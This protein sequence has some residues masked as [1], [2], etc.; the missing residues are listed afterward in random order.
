MSLDANDLEAREI[1]TAVFESKGID[2]VPVTGF[3]TNSG[4]IFGEG[5]RWLGD[6]W[7]YTTAPTAPL[8]LLRE[9]EHATASTLPGPDDDLWA[10]QWHFDFLGDIQKIWEDYTGLGIKV[11]IHDDGMD[12]TF[13]DVDGVPTPVVDH[14]DLA[15]NYDNT[16]E[17]WI[18]GGSFHVDPY[19]TPLGSSTGRPYYEGSTHGTAVAGLIAAARN[20]VG[21]VGVAY[22]STFSTVDI[23]SGYK[24]TDVN[25][26]FDGFFE[27]ALQT[28]NF[29]VVNNS[30][31]DGAYFFQEFIDPY[32]Y[33]K[34][35]ATVD[36]WMYALE[37]G[38]DGLGTLQVKA[39][40]N[41]NLNANGVSS[42]YS[43]ATII[44]GAFDDD[45]DAAYYSNH[46]ANLLV[47]APS[48]GYSTIIETFNAG[49]VTTDRSGAFIDSG[50]G[51]YLYGYNGLRDENGQRIS[52]W[53]PDFGGTSGATP[54][55]TGVIALLLQANEDLGWRDVQNIL[56][57]SAHEQGSGVGGERLE[58]ETNRWLYNN[59]DNW[60]GGGLHFSN[61]YGFGGVD[62]YNAVRMAE[63]WTLFGGPKASLNETS[64][65]QSTTARVALDDGK[66]T[67][68]NFTF[69]GGEFAVD[70][71]NVE[72]VLSHEFTD[73]LEIQ[74]I[75]PDGTQV[76][77]VDFNI[78]YYYGATEGW[79]AQFGVNTFRGEDGSGEWTLRIIDHW[80]EDAGFLDSAKITLHG[81]DGEQAVN[82]LTS[83]VYH[84]TSEVFKS[85]EREASRL[86]ITDSDGGEDWIDAAAMS[87]NL[88]GPTRR[89]R[90]FDSGRR[91]LRHHCER[92][93]DRKCSHRRWQRR[94]LRQRSRQQ[95]LRYAWQRCAFWR[96]RP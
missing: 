6:H 59:A 32:Y 44:V 33:Y 22:D 54:I 17:A 75:S 47:S 68:I 91:C 10:Y 2:F 12:A 16:L 41:Q 64:F 87:S 51:E 92:N 28:T 3:S 29:D 86:T 85:L 50:G 4:P 45:G 84:Y 8:G 52:D 9:A 82:D 35:Q 53:T 95:A 83:D 42:Q 66:T 24:F 43:R 25:S 73:D 7:V 58:N 26:S 15:A 40:G 31:G 36:A 46:G 74:L 37:N 63:V 27:A 90:N 55:V 93:C 78:Q 76:T 70:F 34:G 89:R 96:H 14:P 19:P 30:W 79:K 80:V 21:T 1:S 69:D 61:D 49:L 81:T 38:R 5:G 88:S 23:L 56:A 13:I 11:G 18:F 71:V 60:N 77:L 94:T 20:G 57:Y 39:A 72:V 67:D 65:S 62:A 48:S